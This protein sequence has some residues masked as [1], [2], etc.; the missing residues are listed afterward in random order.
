MTRTRIERQIDDALLAAA[1]S[2]GLIYARRRIRRIRRILAQ[3]AVLAG[4]GAVALVAIG[5]AAAAAS[6]RR[7]RADA[8]D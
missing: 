3:G 4:A 8:V 1:M 5:A 2:A 6:R 7:R